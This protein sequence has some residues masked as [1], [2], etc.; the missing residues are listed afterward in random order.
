LH[1]AINLVEYNAN[2]VI[3]HRKTVSELSA[4]VCLRAY[5]DVY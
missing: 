4:S 5:L 1:I 3:A 2:F